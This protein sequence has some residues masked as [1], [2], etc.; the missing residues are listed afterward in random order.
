MITL[1]KTFEF[2]WIWAT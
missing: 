1:A 2:D